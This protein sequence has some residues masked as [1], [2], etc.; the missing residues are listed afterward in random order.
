MVKGI[1]QNMSKISASGDLLALFKPIDGT[2]SSSNCKISVPVNLFNRGGRKVAYALLELI[3]E[4]KKALPEWRLKLDS[5]SITRQ[6]KPTYIMT[7]DGGER[8]IFKFVYDVTS[9]LNVQDIASKEWINIT[10][11]YEGGEPFTVK[12]V[13]L[14]ALYEDREAYSTYSHSTGLMLLES[15]DKTEFAV[16]GLNDKP[17]VL[18]LIAY[19]P[20]RST[21]DVSTGYHK[22]TVPLQQGHVEEYT[23]VLNEG[24]KS[25]EVVANNKEDAPI[26]LSS[27]TAYKSVVKQPLL[28]LCHV[29]YSPSTKKPKLKL[30]I[31][32]KGESSPDA[33][34]ISLLRKGNLLYTVQER[35]VHIPPGHVWEKLLELPVGQLDELNVRLVWFKLTRRWVRDEV[36]K[37]IG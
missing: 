30:S 29:D 35:K 21:L 25:I 11:K 31:C 19:A 3:V 8:G 16:N 20:R 26:V 28:E 10:V 12:S 27:I 4:A 36:I 1:L 24:V 7:I 33:V 22:F 5:I 23:V 15:G 14:D 32:N 9:I 34:I 13:L 17:I 6:F 18:R 37:G 2:L